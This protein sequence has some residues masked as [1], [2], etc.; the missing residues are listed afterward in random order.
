RDSAN[1]KAGFT[2]TEKDGEVSFTNTS[3]TSSN[4]TL[5]IRWQ[6]NAPGI[7]YNAYEENPVVNFTYPGNFVVTI[8]AEDKL[9]YCTSYF[10]DTIEIKNVCNAKFAYKRNNSTLSFEPE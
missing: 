3:T 9:G 5:K 6:I 1:C 4:D 8:I 10:K 7:Y 2:Y